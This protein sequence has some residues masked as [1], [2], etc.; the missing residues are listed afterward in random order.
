L[1]SRL[2]TAV[3]VL[4][5]VADGRVA[6]IAGATSD[7]AERI[8]AGELVNFVA[9]Q[10]GGRGGGRADMAQAGGDQPQQLDAALASVLPH[11][12]QALAAVVS[13]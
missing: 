8:P 12:E 1:K 11:V 6:L 5:A 2:V 9:G 10:V 4:G 13:H 7:V 3:V